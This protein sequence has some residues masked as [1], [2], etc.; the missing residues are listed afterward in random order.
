MFASVFVDYLQKNNLTAYKVAKETGISQ[1][2]MNQYK[3]G[4]KTPTV[5]NLLKISNY[6]NCSVD[7]LLGISDDPSRAGQAAV[8]TEENKNITIG[9]TP[10]IAERIKE[11][12][13]RQD[14]KVKDL[15]AQCQID[16]N[17]VNKLAN[18]RDTG[19][20]NICK[21]AD[22]LNCSTDYLLGLSNDPV[23]NNSPDLNTNEIAILKLFRQLSDTQQGILIGRAELM[24][25]EN[26]NRYEQEG[27]G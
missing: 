8:L 3:N 16:R 13:H 20:Q 2:L 11:E 19:T 23:K 17:L 22:F 9:N 6:L 27:A 10:I 18:G 15:L 14:V 7:Y 12:A 21:I 4:V 24:V 25:E 5:D 26:D 1:G